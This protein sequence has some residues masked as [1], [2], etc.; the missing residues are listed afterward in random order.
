MDSPTN[1]DS[2]TT[3]GMTPQTVVAE[4]A[5]LIGN[6]SAPS[7]KRK[8]VDWVAAGHKAWATRR[9]NAALRL[10]NTDPASTK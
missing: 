1:Q 6:T 2:E 7:N 8:S 10:E 9:R 4:H 3:H 5:L